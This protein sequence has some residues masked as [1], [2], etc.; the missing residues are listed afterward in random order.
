MKPGVTLCSLLILMFATALVVNADVAR[1]KTQPSKQNVYSS[2][3]IVPDGKATN[4]TLQIRQS[5][6][7]A[8]RAALDSTEKPTFA[9][10]ITHS[11]SRT[12][13]AGVLLFMSVSFAGVWLAR[14]SRSG[15]GMGRRQKAV[16]VGL[17]G[18]ATIGAAAIITRGNAGPPPSY[19][20][21]NLAASLAA[22]ESTAGPITIQIVADDQLPNTGIKLTIPLKKTEK[23]GEDE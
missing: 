21:R 20:W 19:R 16:A 18:L 1:P 17:I 11:G 9:A 10:S 4:A 3:E 6:L 13:I 5:D 2:L 22:G 15:K 7:T 8:L 23:T 14:S 12:I